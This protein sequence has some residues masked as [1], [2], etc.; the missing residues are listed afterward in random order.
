[1]LLTHG[2][3]TKLCGFC[4]AGQ[5]WDILNNCCCTEMNLHL[6]YCAF[7]LQILEPFPEDF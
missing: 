7:L 6:L 4:I 2:T 5:S 1:M 3:L